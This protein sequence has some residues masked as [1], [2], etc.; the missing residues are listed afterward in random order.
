MTS[1][2]LA[3]IPGCLL[4]KYSHREISHCIRVKASQSILSLGGDECLTQTDNTA[5]SEEK[6]DLAIVNLAAMPSM[7]DSLNRVVTHLKPSGYF[8]LVFFHLPSMRNWF[9][10][11]LEKDLLKR[12]QL[13]WDKGSRLLDD[14]LGEGLIQV[15]EREI[16]QIPPDFL[17]GTDLIGLFDQHCESFNDCFDDLVLGKIKRTLSNLGYFLEN[18]NSNLDIYIE[19]IFGV[20][21]W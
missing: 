4:K 20:R 14:F 1:I 15:V 18:S 7:L 2:S 19:S 9:I 11:E 21:E 3:G 10:Y 12:D 5:F 17:E 13:I 8:G 6:F 16:V